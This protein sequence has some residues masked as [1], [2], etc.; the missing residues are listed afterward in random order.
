MDHRP[1][2]RERG[3]RVTDD[4][5]RMEERFRHEVVDTEERLVLLERILQLRKK[6]GRS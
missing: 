4:L 3:T 1:T 6:A 5:A 2:I